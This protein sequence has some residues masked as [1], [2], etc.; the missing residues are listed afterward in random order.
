MMVILVLKACS[1]PAK[2]YL[3]IFRMTVDLGREELP[4]FHDPMASPEQ[5]SAKEQHSLP[6]ASVFLHHF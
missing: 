3:C 6:H 5:P 2:I 4:A 1:K